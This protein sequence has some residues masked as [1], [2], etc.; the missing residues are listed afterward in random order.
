MSW[1]ALQGQLVVAIVALLTTFIAYT[2]QIFVIWNFLGG[3]S[4]HT[5]LILIPLNV[6]I[7]L[8]YINYAL[9]CL[10]DPGCVPENWMPDTQT[11]MEVKRSTHEPR[12]CKTCNNYKPPRTHHCSTCGRCVLKMDHHCPW[13]NSCVGFYNYGHF[14]R[15]ITYIEISAIYLFILLGCRLAQVI[16]EMNEYNVHPSTIEAAFLAI[17]LI[18]SFAAIVTVGILSGYHVYC[19]TTN[20]TTIEGW[21]KGTALTMKSHTGKISD[22]KYPY[23]LG[24]Y[25]NVC[26]V[27]GNQ[28]LFWMWPQRMQGNGLYFPMRLQGE[29][30]TST[31][32]H[33]DTDE[34][35]TLVRKP[36]R[37]HTRASTSSN[38]RVPTTP[39]SVLTFNTTSTLVDP[40]FTA[41][42]PSSS[43]ETAIE[44]PCR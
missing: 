18:L 35:A 32:M 19:L 28:P 29:K 41:K 20:T 44:L 17:N 27:L 14:I 16:H 38:L 43:K 37:L 9:V 21:E 4:L 13:I 36:S 24:W 31:L 30:R 6:F 26:S 8:L 23:N 40:L 42:L 22:V 2:S 3:A 33:E 7:I 11:H 12:F 15:F 39:A 25:R 10:T 34:F 5:L 1:K